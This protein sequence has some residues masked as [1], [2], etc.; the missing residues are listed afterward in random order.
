MEENRQPRAPYFFSRYF[1]LVSLPLA[2]GYN[3]KI[4]LAILHIRIGLHY[5][6]VKLFKFYAGLFENSLLRLA[7]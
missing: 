3:P 4:I 5:F 2:I 1:L 7:T 6:I